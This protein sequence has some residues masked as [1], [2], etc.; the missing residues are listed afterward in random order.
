M[1]KRQQPTNSGE[2]SQKKAGLSNQQCQPHP[3]SIEE[4]FDRMEVVVEEVKDCSIG[5]KIGGHYTHIAMK[6]PNSY[7]IGTTFR[8]IRLE[9]NNGAL[10]YSGKLT[11]A[12]TC[13]WDI[14]YASSP[15]DCYFLA[16]NDKLYRKDIDAKPPYVC[17][18]I[19]CGYRYGACLRY[20]EVHQRLIFNKDDT[21]LAVFNP[22]TKRIEVV[23]KKS[24]GEEI[25]DFRLF[26]R[27]EDRVAAVTEDGHVILY[28]LGYG[29]KR[30]VMAHYQEEMRKS[31]ES[32]MTFAVCVKNEYVFVEFEN[33]QRCSRMVILKLTLDGLVKTASID[34]ESQKLSEKWAL[35]CFGYSGK[36]I[37]WVG[38]S[39]EAGNGGVHL[40]D[41]ETEAKKLREL[42]D[43]RVSH[44]EKNPNSM[45]RFGDKIYYTGHSGKLMSLMLRF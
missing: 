15:L 18:S 23:L 11:G 25:C 22:K 27:Q 17:L 42:V 20:S 4:H 1:E 35:D 7:L 21:N 44:F 37:L 26:G 16:S 14:I 30:G 2:E 9:H 19:E 33:R 13:I 38:L 8:G 3:E 34:Q 39:R 40:F 5:Y 29:N 28:S 45:L 32:A 6:N 24:F 31:S 41:Y 43:K 36:H 10:T 12:S